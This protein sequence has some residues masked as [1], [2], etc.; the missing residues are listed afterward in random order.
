MIEQIV[1]SLRRVLR[2]ELYQ[3]AQVAPAID[4]EE[5]QTATGEIA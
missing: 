4:F 1:F 3:I 5:D 2:I